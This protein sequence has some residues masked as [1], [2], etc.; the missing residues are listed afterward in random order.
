MHEN[1]DK[2]VDGARSKSPADREVWLKGVCR[3]ND[4]MIEEVKRRLRAEMAVAE[5]DDAV[6]AAE[7][8]ADLEAVRSTSVGFTD[9]R[10]PDGFEFVSSIGAGAFGEVVLARNRTDDTLVALKIIRD[11]TVVEL[12][13][14]RELRNRVL[15]HKNV[16]AV[17]HVGEW[18]DCLYCIMPLADNA[19]GLKADARGGDYRALTLAVWIERNRRLPVEDAVKI[20]LAMAEGARHLI[21]NGVSHSDI[22]PENVIRVGDH[23][24]L[25]D[26]GLLTD[27]DAKRPRGGTPRYTPED[28]F[29]TQSGDT[30]AIAMCL[31]Q[32]ITGDAPEPSEAP[33]QRYRDSPSGT[34]EAKV[35]ELISSASIP[36]HSRITLEEMCAELR[37]LARVIDKHEIPRERSDSPESGGRWVAAAVAGAFLPVGLLLA[38]PPAEVGLPVL[39]ALSGAVVVAGT[40]SV[41]AK[42]TGMLRFV[43]LAIVVGTAGLYIVSTH[44]CTTT[45]EGNTDRWTRVQIGFGMASWSLDPYVASMVDANPELLSGPKELLLRFDWDTATGDAGGI[46]RPWTIVASTIVVAGLFSIASLCWFGCVVHV[47]ARRARAYTE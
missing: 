47:Q 32:M 43:L 26:H 41:W 2:I 8:T 24:Q 11:R 29:G 45:E 6:T 13:G 36:S 5:L 25:T 44:Y 46:W 27:T 28:E 16:C 21:E 39:G 15:W 31:Y 37:V 20:A 1:I 19:R 34:L 42:I 9:P 14:L 12:E 30:F 23:W 18:N 40:Q 22:K 7:R 10:V 3:G 17:Q 35:R 4:R 33:N 38:Q